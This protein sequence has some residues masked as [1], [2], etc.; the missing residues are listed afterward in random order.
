MWRSYVAN[1]WLSMFWQ[2][3]RPRG[4]VRGD[5]TALSRGTASEKPV[6]AMLIDFVIRGS[7]GIQSGSVAALTRSNG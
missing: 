3:Q 1:A 2:A 5:G 7:R 6:E 4:R